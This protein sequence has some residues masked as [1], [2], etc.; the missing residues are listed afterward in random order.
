[1]QA[2]SGT[3]LLISREMQIQ[4]RE[5]PSHPHLRTAAVKEARTGAAEGVETGPPAHSWG[6]GKLCNHYGK[7]VGSS[8]KAFKVEL[9]YDSAV[10]LLDI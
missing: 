7:T 4:T 6:V 10:L 3:L 5:A 1:V 8:L 2:S 9:P